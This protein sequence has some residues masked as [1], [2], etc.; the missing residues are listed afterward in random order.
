ML[1]LLLDACQVMMGGE[2]FSIQSVGFRGAPAKCRDSRLSALGVI[3]LFVFWV[4][5]YHG[6][7]ILLKQS[8][9]EIL[10]LHWVS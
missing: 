2:Q 7:Y 3:P 5:G 4:L 8:G 10:T 9:I 1:L 6:F